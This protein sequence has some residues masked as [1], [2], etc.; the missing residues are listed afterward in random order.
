MMCEAARSLNTLTLPTC[1]DGDFTIEC[2]SSGDEAA[3]S[4]FSTLHTVDS[5]PKVSVT[6]AD[7]SE[8]LDDSAET[9]NE[10]DEDTNPYGSDD[11]L[12]EKLDQR[13]LHVAELSVSTSKLLAP[14]AQ[15]S[16]FSLLFARVISPKADA[17]FLLFLAILIRKRLLFATC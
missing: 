10:T 12:E 4:Y 15:H 9:S 17:Q 16:L 14:K 11:G 3:G 6:L 7:S 1:P 5:Q 8:E 13:F 2:A